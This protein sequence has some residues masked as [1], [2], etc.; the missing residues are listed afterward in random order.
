M[1][2]VQK[3]LM[4]ELAYVVNNRSLAR[5]EKNIYLVIFF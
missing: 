3:E 2:L 1:V 4:P 5:R